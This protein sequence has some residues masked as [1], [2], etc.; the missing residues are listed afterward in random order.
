MLVLFE[1]PAG[2]SLFKVRWNTH[3]RKNVAWQGA[4]ASLRVSL[5]PS[6][7]RP[8]ACFRGANNKRLEPF[9]RECRNRNTTSPYQKVISIRAS[10][11]TLLWLL[12]RERAFF[13]VCFW[14]RL[15]HAPIEYVCCM[16]SYL[17]SCNTHGGCKKRNSLVMIRGAMLCD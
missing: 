8:R 7:S 6:K 2:Y 9:F 4:L 15:L 5:S 11:C 1:T 3:D 13:L 12:Q 10:M 14:F 17:N 16:I